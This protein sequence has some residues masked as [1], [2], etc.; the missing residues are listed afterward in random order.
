[1]KNI[2]GSPA[3]N[4]GFPCD[5]RQGVS[6]LALLIFTAVFMAVSVSLVSLKFSGANSNEGFFQRT[7]SSIL[8][9]F[10]NIF[11]PRVEKPVLEIDLSKNTGTDK[12]AEKNSVPK[13]IKNNSDAVPKNKIAENFSVTIPQNENENLAPTST[14]SPQPEQKT[15][16]EISECDFSKTGNSDH[17]IIFSEVNW[18]GSK[19]SPNDEWIEIKN[20]S[21]SDISLSGWQILSADKNIKIILSDGNKISAG[22]LYLLERT[23]DNSAPEASADAI[24]S[25]T[26]SNS[27][28]IL[29]IFSNDCSISDE[30]DASKKWPAGDSVSRRS[31][32]RSVLDFSWHTSATDGGTPKKENTA[33]FSRKEPEIIFLQPEAPQNIIPENQ[34]ASSSPQNTQQQ[35]P[36]DGTHILIAEVQTTGG[37]GKTTNDFIKIFNPSSSPFDLKGYRLVKRTK[38]GSS[39][40]SLK[41]WTSDA[42]IPSQGYY[43]WANS[44]FSSLT[45]SP[46]ATTSGSISDDNGIAIRQG[47]EDTGTIIDAVAWGGAQNTFIENSPYAANPGANQI[48]SRKTINGTLQD[49]DNNQNDFEVK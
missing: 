28:T 2:F 43:I 41:S 23:D 36:A 48:L 40:T 29:K 20:N 14:Q 9:T 27:G 13:I 26:L 12:S 46:D 19:E 35:N 33:A 7:S 10:G 31:M 24:Y 1:M 30:I 44:S 21:G 4:S 6:S 32:E 5:A 11:S 15:Q 18:M 45:P 25:G 3:N 17:R 22:S 37:S 42:L 49:T 47:A 39:D 34:T 16:K 38:T 8:K